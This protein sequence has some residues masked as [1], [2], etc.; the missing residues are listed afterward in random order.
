ME[1]LDQLSGFIIRAASDER[2]RPT[3][4]ALYNAL[5]HSWISSSFQPCYHV[6]RRQLMMLSRIRSCTTYHKAMRDLRD[7]GYLKYRP[8][9]HPVK[10][11]EVSLLDVSNLEHVSH[12]PCK[13]ILLTL[14]PP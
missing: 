8:S 13:V 3:H 5:C 14:T 1:T 4:I 12:A 6:S 2:L 10:G 7:F 9:Y 11:S